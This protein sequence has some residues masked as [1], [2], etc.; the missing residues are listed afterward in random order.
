MNQGHIEMNDIQLR[1]LD[2]NLLL[3]LDALLHA[4]EVGLAAERMRLTP[5][6]M[7]HALRRLRIHFDDPLLIK[8]K[9]RMLRTAKAEALAGPLRKALLELE[10]AVNIEAHFSPATARRHFS[11]ATNDYGDLIILPRLMA[12]LAGQAPGID[13]RVSHFDP[14][15]SQAPL[16][17]GNIE[18]ALHH[19]LQRAAEI[20][21][22]LL[23]KDDYCC[24]VRK[25][26]PG[27]ESPFDLENYLRMSHLRITARRDRPDPIDQALSRLNRTRRLALTIPNFSSAPMLVAT[28]DLVLS[29]PRRCIQ[30]WCRILPI[31][32]HELPLELPGFS[33][34]ML[35][36]ERFQ[37][38]PA[39]QWLREKLRRIAAHM[40]PDSPV[41]QRPAS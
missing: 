4:E 32:S 31:E 40:T 18:L 29:A 30:E 8:G 26:H 39:H 20:H 17:T 28:T 33:I 27:I 34:A 41:A 7:S 13:L 12:L 21:Q 6:A 36:H 9:G 23:F 35:W 10:Q 19:P 24:A 25:H 37:R 3:A 2:L 11:I 15:T 1:R 14:E 5:S 38:D 22:Q 16:E